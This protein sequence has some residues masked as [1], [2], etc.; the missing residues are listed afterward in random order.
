MVELGYRGVSFTPCTMRG[1]LGEL[2]AEFVTT[3]KVVVF[4]AT[5]AVHGRWS[6]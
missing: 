6:R 5:Q 2:L 1:D 4:L 3:G